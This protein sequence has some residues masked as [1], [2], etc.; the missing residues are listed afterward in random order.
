MLA[1]FA[2]L[3]HFEAARG[4]Q[5]ANDFAGE[6]YVPDGEGLRHLV[7]GNRTALADLYWL[8]LIQYLAVANEPQP[9]VLPLLCLI[10]NLDPE[11]GYAYVVGGLVLAAKGRLDQSDEILSKGLKNAPTRWEIPFHLAFNAW[12]ERQDHAA[13]AAWLRLA[14]DVPGRPEYL[15]SL[16]ARLLATA[17]DVDA[18]ID[19]SKAM[20][21]QAPNDATRKQYHHKV[22]QL[23]LERDLQCLERA[24]ASFQ[25]EEGRLPEGLKELP[26]E[27][28]TGLSQPLAVFE[29]DPTT[30]QVSTSLQEKRFKVKHV[31]DVQIRATPR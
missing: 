2:H 12:Y 26:V 7:P 17:G 20:A 10:T 11:Y 14:V 27:A 18:A 1:V 29:Y 19:F 16:V 13:G 21:S 24:I 6:L 5:A 4:G 30:G 22:G 23:I 25:E 8:K 9:A 15:P 28:L 31:D 3:A